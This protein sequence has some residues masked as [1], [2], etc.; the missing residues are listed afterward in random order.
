M[1]IALA[2]R[3]RWFVLAALPMDIAI[4]TVPHITGHFADAMLIFP[5][6][7]LIMAGGVF[8]AR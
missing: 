1:K 7:W 5:V 2:R 6:R 4:A 3:W 8:A